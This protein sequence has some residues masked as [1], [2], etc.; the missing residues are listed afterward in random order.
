[1]GREMTQRERMLH[2][3]KFVLVINAY[4]ALVLFWFCVFFVKEFRE[5]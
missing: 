2:F 3:I 4:T 1:M 5:W